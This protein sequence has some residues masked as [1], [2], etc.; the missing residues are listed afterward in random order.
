MDYQSDPLFTDQYRYLPWAGALLMK[1]YF[2]ERRTSSYLSCT[3]RTKARTTESESCGYNSWT[4]SST[5]AQKLTSKLLTVR[6]CPWL[7]DVSS[8]QARVLLAAADG[9]SVENQTDNQQKHFHTVGACRSVSC[10]QFTLLWETYGIMEYSFP[11]DVTVARV[12]TGFLSLPLKS[13][14]LVSNSVGNLG[15]CAV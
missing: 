14:Q 9:L 12:A 15:S 5:E 10:A 6:S 2:W 13:L 1:L 3:R 11:S 8:A 4:V 7:M